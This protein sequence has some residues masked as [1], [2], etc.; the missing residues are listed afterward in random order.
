MPQT[1]ATDHQRPVIYQLLP[2]L[3]TNYTADP[4]PNGTIHTNGSGKL[5]DINPSILSS[6]KKMG[7]THVWY[8]GVIEHGHDADYTAFGIRRNNPYIIKGRAGSPY[9]ITDYYDIDPDIAVNVPERM[10]EFENLVKRTH[11]AGLKVITDFVPNHT[12]REYHSDSCPPGV[13]DF[14]IDDDRDM[15]FRR[16]NNYYYIPRQKFS[17]S[18]FLGDGKDTYVEFPA[19]ATG[20]DCFSAF[21]SKNDW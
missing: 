3:F 17:P 12:A 19:K 4:I 18:I 20:N 8:T 13:R 11:D 10:T 15:F 7:V 5:N 14:G 9:A 21:P 1:K 16:D 6:I 2:R